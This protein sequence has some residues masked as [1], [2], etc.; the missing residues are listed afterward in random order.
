MR[1]EQ[2]KKYIHMKVKKK[3]SL[4]GE[5]RKNVKKRRRNRLENL[6]LKEMTVAD[7]RKTQ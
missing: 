3:I 2:W 5:R 4:H 7:K 1:L 6:S